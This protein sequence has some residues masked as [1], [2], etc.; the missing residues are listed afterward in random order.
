MADWRAGSA[1][2]V[3][4]LL[5]A[6]PALGAYPGRGLDVFD[7]AAIF[8]VSSQPLGIAETSVVLTGPTQIRRGDPYDPGDGLIEIDTQIEQ[9]ALSGTTPIGSVIVKVIAP[10]P[11]KIKQKQAG[12]DFPADSWFE[13]RVEVQIN[14]SFGNF[15]LFSDPNKP[16]LLMAEIDDIPPFGA[17]YMPEGTF[18][19]VD[20]V[21]ELGQVVGLISH[22]GHFVGQHPTFS[23][24]PLGTSN[25]DPADLFGRPTAPRIRPAGLGLVSGDNVSGLS[26]GLDF[27]FPPLMDIRFSVDPNARGRQGSDVRREADKSPKQAHGDEFRVTPFA[28]AVG[29]DNVQVLDENGDTAPPFPLQISDDVDALA[30]QPPEFADGNG[31]GIPEREVYFTLGAGSL[32]LAT[33]NVTPGD[34]LVTSGGNRPTVFINH[35]ELGLTA[36]DEVDAICLSAGGKDIAYSLAP[37]SP[38]LATLSASAADVFLETSL[39]VT[40][41]RR[42]FSAANLGLDPADNLNAMKCKSGEIDEFAQSQ[43][44]FILINSQSTEQIT[45]TCRSG[46]NVGTID[47]RTGMGDFRGVPAYPTSLYC[48]GSSRA[49]AIDLRLRAPNEFPMQISYGQIFDSTDDGQLGIMPWGTGQATFDVYLYLN[50]NIGNVMGL[51]HPTAIQLRGQITGKPPK[52]QES[53]AF[54]TTTTT[55]LSPQSG[56]GPEPVGQAGVVPLFLEG[57]VATNF[58]LSQIS[59]VPDARPKPTFTAAGFTDAAAFS[60]PPSPGGLASLFGTYDT[61]LDVATAIPLP[62]VLGNNV[63][64]RFLV[65]APAAAQSTQSA[66]LSAD[67]K[68]Q[69]AQIELPAP[70][71]FVSGTQINLQIPWEVNTGSGTVT[72]IVSVNG[73]DSDP[74]QLPVA[75]VSPGVFTA[76]SGPGHA[77]AINADG[78]LAHA[79]GSI[80]GLTTRPAVAGQ[81]IILLVTGLGVTS[82]GGVTGDNSY[83]AAGTFVRRDTATVARVRVG[84]LDAP[85]VFS[86]LSPEFVGVFQINA[87]VPAG[88]TPGNAV[89][90]VIEIGGRVS[91]DDVTIAVA[92][93]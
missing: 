34:I 64:V 35:A 4:A 65:N 10:A 7:S 82:P 8:R 18:V 60:K 24:A 86:G 15:R 66:A 50:L 68:N 41:P 55:A 89:P 3:F 40:T 75:A 61:S 53:L 33:L 52:P 1:L 22:V 74:V 91:R 37:G 54:R 42:W 32:S 73:A 39:P 63:Q 20:L 14:S 9:M 12:V 51:H 48:K 21:D 13:V 56:G 43:L 80:P 6:G 11:G 49:G 25:L 16:I 59:Y 28:Q 26:Y 47:G 71:L 30:E 92:A 62:R 38:S 79:A 72:A 69:A 58:S 57:G 88:V 44:R 46:I 31:D 93:P 2:A 81:P 29:G 19:G 70:L 77:I 67:G 85:V 90:L 84:G 83:D 27:L 45:L 87:T 78:S 36:Q 23:V 5:L 17:Q 76:E